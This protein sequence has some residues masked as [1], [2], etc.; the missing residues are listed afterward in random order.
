MLTLARAH[1]DLLVTHLQGLGFIINWQKSSLLLAQNVVFI[2]MS[3]D[4]VVHRAYLSPAR[5]EAFR[6]CLARF[7]CSSGFDLGPL[8]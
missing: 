6:A 5:V 2:G 8:R 3:L 7:C 4:S 1:T